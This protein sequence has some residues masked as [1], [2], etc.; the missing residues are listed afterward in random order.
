VGS[1]PILTIR[2]LKTYFRTYEGVV[3]AVDGVDLAVHEGETLGIVGES[4][5]GKSVMA[6]SILR[7]IP[8]PPGIIVGGEMLFS[9]VDLLKLRE[10]EMRK[11]RGGE[12]SMI[13]QEPMTSLN[14]VYD[15]GDQIS[16]TIRLHQQISRS[17]AYDRTIE[18]LRLVKIPSPEK[19]I[20][21]YPHKM[22]GGMRQRVMI[23]M[24]LACHPKV[25]IADEP[26]TALDVT[27]QAQIL[28]LIQQLREEVGTSIILITH[29]LG[30]IAENAE[31][32]A[33]MYTGKIVEHASV[34]DLF[35][36]PSHPYTR[37]LLESTP[38]MDM[39]VSSTKLA[40]IPGIVPSLT[41]LPSGCSFHDRCSRARGECS[42]SQ[43]SFVEV[44][45]GHYV[46]CWL[47]S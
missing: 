25:M 44:D 29:D 28:D 15:I 17:E 9:G 27:I 6:L 20:K 3:R 42:Q 36:N 14:P 1:E 21:E 40:S 19:R 22:S 8:S 11:I 47:F 39:D 43:P 46:R 26:T 45:R 30:V 31:R 12:I 13:F 41:D 32:V 16:E 34:A 38:R 4:G 18:M 33:V 5:C 35:L 37:G 23:A 7:L 10:S 24:A 2:D